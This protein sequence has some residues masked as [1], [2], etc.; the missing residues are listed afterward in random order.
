MRRAVPHRSPHSGSPSFWPAAARGGEA[1]CIP[2]ANPDAAS[3]VME[4]FGCG[5]CHTIPG[6]DGAD[7]RIGPNLAGIE[8]RW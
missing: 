5:S 1:V 2:G 6:V 4:A 8:G 3:K 7:G